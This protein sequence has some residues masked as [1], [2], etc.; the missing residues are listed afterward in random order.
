MSTHSTDLERLNFLARVVRKE[1]A[2]LKGTDERLFRDPFTE[3]TANRLAGDTELAER[4]DA[5]STRFARLQDT[6]GDKLLPLLL[7]ALGETTGAVIDNLDRAERLGLIESADQW[8][9]LRKLRNQMVHEYIEDLA[10]LADALQTAHNGVPSL[11]SSTERMIRELERRGWG[12][13]TD[14]TG[15]DS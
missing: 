13:N 7:Q 11:T 1:C 14:R 12:E 8:M 6:L 15:G 5:F 10:V 9:V 4:V 3:K 2:H